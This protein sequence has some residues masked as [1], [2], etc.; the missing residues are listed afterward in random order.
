M[1][2]VKDPTSNVLDL[3]EVRFVTPTLLLPS[4]HFARENSSTILVHPSTSNYVKRVLG[5]IDGPDTT[6]P[7]RELP[8]E[9]SEN[10]TVV[11][12]LLNLLEQYG[13]DAHGGS[14]YGGSQTLKH[15][16][17]EMINNV[18]DHSEAK[19]GYTYAQHYPNLGAI[20]ICFYDDGI[21]IPCSYENA[22]IPFTTD[23]DAIHKSINGISTKQREGDDP[24]GYGINT[25]A[26]LI[27]NGNQGSMLIA[28]RRGLYYMDENGKKYKRLKRKN[29]IDGTLVSIRVQK[30]QVQ[31]F[32]DYMQ[33]TDLI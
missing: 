5:I 16:L 28:S 25:T 18:I 3:S 29:R 13:K 27:I 31:N 17:D 26:Q 1:K 9:R 15:L 14:K 20:D 32:Y 24:R 2:V 19:H 23:C 7:F 6:L 33:H 11:M 22:D 21:S 30:N 4:L 8:K 12:D 10:N